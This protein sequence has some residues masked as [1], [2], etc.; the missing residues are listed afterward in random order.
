V[1]EVVVDASVAAMWV[2]AERYS[3]KAEILLEYHECFA[4]NHWLAEAVNAVWGR[5]HRGGISAAQ[6]EAATGLLLNAPVSVVPIPGLMRRALAISLA[7][8]VTIYDAL[9][10]A[11]AERRGVRMVTGDEALIRRVATNADLAGLVRWV[12]DLP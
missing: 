11:L 12:G 3:D 7:T 10:L 6:A 1:T 8:S 2:L 9:Y 5:F 4:P